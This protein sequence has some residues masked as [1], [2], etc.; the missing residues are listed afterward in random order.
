MSININTLHNLRRALLTALELSIEHN[1]ETENVDHITDVLRQVELTV[2]LQQESIYAIAGMQGAGKTTLA[3]AILG[4][5]D[6]WLDAN[7]G[8]GEQVP[9]FIEQVD[10]DPSDFPQVVYQCLNL[11]TGEIAPQKGEGGEQLQSLLRD[12]SSIRRYEKAGFKLLYPKLLISK[13]N[14]FINE[15][16]T[17]ALLPGY[18]VATSKNYLWQDMM[19]HVLVNARGVMFVTDPSLLANDSKS[20]VLQ[21]LRDNFKERGPV[22]VISKTEMLGEH[23]IKQLKTSAAERV[24]PNV[25]MKKEDIVAT[26]SGNNDIWIDALR[27]TVINKL[28]SSAVSEAIAL[29]NF[30]GLIRE[31]VAEII[32]N[33]KIL[34]D[35]QQ[36]HES[37]VDEILDVFDES[38]STHE[39]KL[40]EA[41]KKETRQH[42]TDALKYCEKSYKREE[43]GFQ[44]NL[45]IFARRLSFRGIE[46]DDERS[47]RIIDAWNRQY[48]NISIHEHNFDALTSVNTRVLRAKGLLPVV[49]NQ[50]LLPGSAVGRMGYLVQDKQAEYSIMDPDLMTGLYTLLKKPGGAHQAPPP[51]KLAAALEIMPALMLENA[52]TR[53]AM[54]LDPACTTQLA[55]E[56]QPKQ[57][58]DA[59]FSSREQYHPIKT[60]MMAFLGADAADGTVDGKSTP[61]TEGGFAPLALV[62][63]AALVASVAYGIYQL[64]GVIRD[65][66]KAQIYYIRRVMEELSFHNEQ[67]VIG[68]YKEMIGE[69]RDYIAYNLKQIFGETDALANRSALTL[70]IKN[71]VAAQKEAKLYETHFRKILG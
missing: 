55:E 35:T 46:V 15:Q 65:S 22:V 19:R 37:I 60:A 61:N 70:A 36:H 24:F 54:H 71:L 25:G 32:N 9:L 3:K 20:A 67:T 52:R 30:M 12:W 56:I 50:Q 40:R 10:G 53:L 18:E 39:Q 33:L 42:F 44:K 58:F 26:G 49:E 43:V 14:S 45:K 69:L 5:D 17:W 31:D 41:I 48:E 34:A 59:L 28:T 62:G 51:K 57:I 68:N 2:L 11:K 21:D 6:E 29:D 13:K 7:P 27:D 23:E 8:R 64:T 47:Q 66:D 16:V 4:I 38:A 63:K 1:E